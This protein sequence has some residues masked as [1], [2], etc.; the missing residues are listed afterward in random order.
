MPV[1][2]REFSL[3]KREHLRRVA[4]EHDLVASQILFIDDLLT[5]LDQVRE[6][7]THLVLA[8]WGYNTP[9]SRALAQAQGIPVLDC[10][11]LRSYCGL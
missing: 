10:N 9:H 6:L 4:R 7:G 3:D 8:S 2:G 11:G 1:I 5:N